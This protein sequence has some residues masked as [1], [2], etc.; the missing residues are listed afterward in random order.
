[1]CGM[2]LWPILGIA[3]LGLSIRALRRRERFR[4]IALFLAVAALLGAIYPVFVFL[5]LYFF[6][7]E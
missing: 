5:F 1:M 2:W 3:S 6:W 4:G 7:K